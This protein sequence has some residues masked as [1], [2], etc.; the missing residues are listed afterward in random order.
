MKYLLLFLT[1]FCTF[2]LNAQSIFDT[3]GSQTTVSRSGDMATETIDRISI[4]RRIFIITNRANSF[5]KG[6]FITLLVNNEPVARAVAAKTTDNQLAGIKILTIYTLNLWNE[7]RVGQQVQIFRGDDSA[8]RN[9]RAQAEAGPTS[10]IASEEDLFNDTTFLEDDL[11]FDDN[12]NR[13]IKND[14]L[15]GVYYSQV[16]GVDNDFSTL[17][18]TMPNI[19]YGYQLDDNIFIEGVL[20][21]KIIND[22]PAL[23]LDTTLTNITARA[24]YTFA[25][26]YLTFFQPYVGFQILN[27]TSPE[28]GEPGADA[29]EDELLKELELLAETSKNRIVFGVTVMRRLVPGWF[30]RADLGSDLLSAGLSLEF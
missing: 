2:S 16:E 4:S 13:V 12:Q 5:G 8:L 3:F 27:A 29:T 17:R 28:A 30:I 22:F 25:G 15:V 19:S 20:G 1:I 10:L 9:Q 14:H 11:Q 23:G 26:P 21:R 6:D 7:L 24:K 18:H